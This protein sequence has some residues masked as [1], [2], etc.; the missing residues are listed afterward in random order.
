MV[1]QN[2]KQIKVELS[3]LEGVTGTGVGIIRGLDLYFILAFRH[4][5]EI[6]AL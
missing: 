1:V 3:G 5:H 4:C 6:L 2:T